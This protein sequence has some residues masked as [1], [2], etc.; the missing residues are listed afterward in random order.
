MK[1]RILVFC[2][3]YLPGI[4]GGGG[5]WAVKNIIDRFADA[6]NFF[7]VTRN[8][9]GRDD[10]TPY[11]T[12]QPDNWN[13]IGDSQVF[14]LAPK[15]ITYRRVGDIV[16]EIK[17]DAVFLNSVFSTP[18]VKFLVARKRR[19]FRNVPVV[20]ATCGEL[21]TATLKMKRAK[22]TAYLT[23]AKTFG[24]YDNLIW[25]ASFDEEKA[26]IENMF[27]SE[28]EIHI[29]PDLTPKTILPNYEQSDKPPKSS[30]SVKFIFVSRI[31][32]KKNLL[33]FLEIL[34]K[35]KSGKI[36]LEIVGSTEDA[37]YW[38]E[39]RRAISV[40]GENINISITGPVSNAEALERLLN[41]HFFVLPTLNE[42]FGYVCIEALAAGC[43]MLLSDQTIWSD[44]ERRGF[45]WNLPLNDEQGWIDAVESAVRMDAEQFETMSQDA[46][47]FA[48]E[49]LAD[50]S[51]QQATADL[52][53]LAISRSK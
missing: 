40:L 50:S 41:S 5:M 16:N 39:C 7:V 21:S 24:L 18:V 9:D 30:G 26:E 37:T 34:R 31:A 17:P 43:P 12:V 51:I 8:H 4:K 13:D 53:G 6:Y 36:E 19:M 14:Y 44:L 23:A 3:Y 38:E 11:T 29:A 20:L 42:N 48:I 33:F 52:L 10:L 45:G 15:Q 47:G 35:C 1:P 25:R 27:G 49:W 32:R 28:C 22:K 46:R 2:D